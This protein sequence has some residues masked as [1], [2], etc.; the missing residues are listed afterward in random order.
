MKKQLSLED[1]KKD[2]LERLK[3]LRPGLTREAEKNILHTDR[4]LWEQYMEDFSPEA[5]AQ[6]LNSGL[7]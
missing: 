5:A 2:V 1:Y 3:E 6:G 7:I 4:E